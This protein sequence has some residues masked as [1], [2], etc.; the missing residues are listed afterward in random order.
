MK[1]ESKLQA[2]C[3]PESAPKSN[4]VRKLYETPQM[5]EYGDIASL[6]Q[7]VVVAGVDGGMP[8][9]EATS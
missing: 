1:S 4:E 7:M 6:V 2:S 8:P 9:F 3:A 5:S